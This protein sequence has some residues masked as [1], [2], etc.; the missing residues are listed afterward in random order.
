MESISS[1]LLS[2]LKYLLPGFVTAWIFHALTAHPKQNQFE[3]IIQALIFT[4]FIQC[5]TNITEYLS[6]LI[7][8]YFSIGVWDDSSELIW[9]VVYSIL[10]GFTLVY[11]TNNGKFHH[12]LSNLK[13][14]KQTSHFSEWEDVFNEVSW[15][16][17]LNLKNG[18]RVYGWPLVWP[19]DPKSGH[20]VL[21]DPE[22]ING[23]KYTPLKNTMY[24]V[25]E[26][27]DIEY[28]EFLKE[29]PEIINAE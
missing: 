28:V 1:E 3:R 13:I 7:G 29:E 16:V 12:F 4:L 5:A 24:L 10:I 22:W 2:V 27:Q 15:F 8:K 23:D 18:R 19:S 17:I 11:Y 9:S 21:Q 26:S 25:I 20:I 6:L 14:T